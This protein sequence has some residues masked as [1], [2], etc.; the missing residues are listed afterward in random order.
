MN[1]PTATAL[2]PRNPSTDRA[3]HRLLDETCA[4]YRAA[5]RFAWHF[6]R[7]KLG[8]DPVF[9]G[10]LERGDLPPRAHVVDIGCGQALLASLFAT[11][12]RWATENRW[13]DGW[14]PALTG[15]R[16]TGIELMRR[17]IERAERSLAGLPRRPTLMCEDMRRAPLPRCDLVVILDVLHYVDHDDQA[18]LLAR[19]RDA[20]MPRG[21]LLMRIG[22]MDQP[23][24]YAMSQW[25]DR[26][27]ARVRGHQVPPTWGRTLKEWTTLLSGLG[28]R[29]SS[30]PMSFGT[31]FANV[32]LIA[33]LGTPPP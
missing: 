3:W 8:R 10:M 11:S 14:P 1:Q 12:E 32:L 7:G 18:A 15:M 33:D 17:D 13:P 19:V 9:R 24:G 25:V 29:V 20:L 2:A 4:P 28:F 22:D 23:R 16:Y 21:R 30:T 27:V 26:T 5:G 6:A 31:P